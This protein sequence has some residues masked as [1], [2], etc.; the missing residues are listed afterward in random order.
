MKK[1]IFGCA[2]TVPA[3]VGLMNLAYAPRAEALPDQT[4]ETEYYSDA[5]YTY[6]VGGSVLLCSG[7]RATWGTTSPYKQVWCSPC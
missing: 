7:R 1:L 4:C 5:T 2:L 3:L 6:S